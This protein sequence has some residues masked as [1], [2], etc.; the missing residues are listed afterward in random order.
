MKMTKVQVQEAIVTIYGHMCEGKLD[1]EIIADMGLTPEE[2]KKLRSA[3]F[4]AKADEVRSTPTEHV[5][6]DYMIK[7][8][9]NIKDLTDMIEEF[10]TTKQYTALVGAV[11]VRAEL[12]DKLIA[13]GQ[14]F[15]LIH[16]EPDKKQVLAGVMVADLSNK[17]LKTMI[18]G[19]LD[20]LNQLMARYGDANIMDMAPGKLHHG[21]RL[22]PTIDADSAGLA[23]KAKKPVAK[24][25]RAKN[26]KRHAGRKVQKAKM[27]AR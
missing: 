5:Y 4:D 7:Q 15:G 16:K 10:K 22:P 25:A 11:R 19:E 9:R 18:V 12:Y 1:N 27:K 26:T 8:A 14:E 13:K 3:M 23:A 21:P 24:T 17:Q 6:V 2:Y 20:N